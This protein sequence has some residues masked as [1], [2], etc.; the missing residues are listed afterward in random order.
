MYIVLRT[1]IRNPRNG[2]G[3]LGPYNK[4]F[5][6]VLVQQQRDCTGTWRPSVETSLNALV[7]VPYDK[8]NQTQVKVYF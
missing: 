4:V 6:H 7:V 3:N 1:M 8:L 2:T 5:G